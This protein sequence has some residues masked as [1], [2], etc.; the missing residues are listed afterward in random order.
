MDGQNNTPRPKGP[1]GTHTLEQVLAAMR[2]RQTFLVTSHARP[3][4]DAVGSVLACWMLLTQMGK[5]AEMVLYDGVPLLYRTMPG[6][7]HIRCLQTIKKKYDAVVFLECDGVA[8]TRLGGLEGQFFI[9]ID[10]HA[11]A[12]AFAQINWIDTRASAVAEMVYWLAQAAQVPITPEMATCVYTSVLTD[13]GSFCYEC[14]RAS[15]FALA[16]D[17]V[18]HGAN[19][20][21]VAQDVYFSNPTSKMRLLGAALAT[22]QREGPIAWLWV[23]RA[24]M[25]R[26]GAEDEDC[27]GIV[28]YAISLSG[29]EV[30]V[31][32][33]EMPDHRFRLSLRSKG[34][35]NVARVAELFGGGGHE[36]AGGCTLEG[37]LSAAI[38]CIL[39]E[40]RHHMRTSIAANVA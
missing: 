36:N 32:L 33:R 12:R 26:A 39:K 27:E 22:L 2:E 21:Q 1:L 23:G 15:T 16:H 5:K 19:P 4:G 29:V 7:D 10:H 9:N 18:L 38:D 34:Q 20:A 14:T 25:A 24:E 37:P 6:A 17:L 31:F 28:N 40:L 11:S 35:I 3:D 13:T 8:R 30:A